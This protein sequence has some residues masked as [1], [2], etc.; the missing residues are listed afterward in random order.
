M[1]SK[2][3][4]DDDDDDDDVHSVTIE[5]GE[6]QVR[7]VTEELSQPADPDVNGERELSE[8]IIPA[9]PVEEQQL[10]IEPSVSLA[11]TD[12]TPG[13]PVFS[14]VSIEKEENEE[15]PLP[16]PASEDNDGPL[17]TSEEPTSPSISVQ[18]EVSPPADDTHPL[19]KIVADKSNKEASSAILNTVCGQ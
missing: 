6:T 1:S 8:D 13:V 5:D 2:I 10:E 16:P 11:D 17:P 9:A 7:E 19:L 3:K 4:D 15:D 12:D 14:D 18:S